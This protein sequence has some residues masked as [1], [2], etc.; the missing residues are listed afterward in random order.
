MFRSTPQ[1]IRPRRA[2]V[3]ARHW[4]APDKNGAT[5]PLLPVTR[6]QLR[7]LRLRYGVQR[8]HKVRDC[9]Q[10]ELRQ[11]RKLALSGVRLE[12]SPL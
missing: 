8:I 2:C 7:Q 3:A 11:Q 9:Y 1:R 12:K 6:R 10:E 5:R 4:S